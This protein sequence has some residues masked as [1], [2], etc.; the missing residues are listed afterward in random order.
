MATFETAETQYTGNKRVPDAGTYPPAER[1]PI[2]YSR[3]AFRP[4]ARRGFNPTIEAFARVEASRW[5]V[6]CPLPDPARDD[7]PCNGAQFASKDDRRTW[8]C[9][10]RNA[11]VGGQ[12]LAVVFPDD[13]MLR[14]IERTLGK[15]PRRTNRN[16]S[17]GESR[18]QLAAENRAMGVE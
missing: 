17:P 1:G 7:E 6:D 2:L 11:A 15:R 12:W 9:D 18:T 10:C 14:A 13:S 4:S 16:W 8:C 3:G 5:I